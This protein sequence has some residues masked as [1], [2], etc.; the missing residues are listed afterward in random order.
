MRPL[1]LDGIEN[2]VE[3]ADLADRSIKLVFEAVPEEKRRDEKEMEAEFEQKHPTILGALLDAVSHGLSE[4]PV[5]RLEKL[6]RMADFALWIAA[7]EGA[8]WKQGTFGR[9][10]DEN[11]R[12]ML[13]DVAQSDI[14][15]GAVSAFFEAK[16]WKYNEKCR[17]QEH[18]IGTADELL[19]SLTSRADLKTTLDP[20]W[21][22]NA[23]ASSQRLRR[24]GTGL[25]TAG[26]EVKM[27]DSAS[28]RTIQLW[29]ADT[30]G[31]AQIAEETQKNSYPSTFYTP[32]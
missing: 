22:K 32:F 8:L 6:P 20:A 30:G 9:I 24:I 5:T 3:R 11:R 13:V 12:D 7:C 17:E 27:G 18:W 28:D 15:A 23:R 2:F 1:I 21:P 14:V 25:L 4:L 29:P 16:E 31:G 26:I 10:Y 19:R